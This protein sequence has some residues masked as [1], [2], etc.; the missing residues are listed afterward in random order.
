MKHK[1]LILIVDDLKSNRMVIKKV[2]QNNYDFIEAGDGIE[3]INLLN[4]FTPD[5][6]LV[7]AIMPN[8]DGFETILKIRKMKKYARTPIL[9]I[10]SLSD[11]KMKVKALEYGVNDFL[12]KPFDKYELRARC[13][14]YVE[15]VQLNKQYSDA[16]I[17]PISGFK[18]EISLIKEIVPNDSIFLISI[19]DFNKI[20]GTYGFRN[21]KIIEK[22]F[23]NYLLKMIKEYIS[24]IELYHVGTA[25]YVIKI[26]KDIILDEMQVK[27]LC[28]EFY[29]NCLNINIQIDDITFMPITTIIFTKD[30]VNLYEDAMSALGY[31]K[32]NNIK[33]IYSSDDINGIKDIVYTNIQILKKIKTAINS[34]KIINYYQPI[35][36]NLTEKVSKY[37]TLVRIEDENGKIL[38]PFAFLEVAKSAQVYEQITKMVYKNAFDKFKFNNNEFSINISYIDIENKTVKEYLYNILKDNPHVSNRITF[39]IL[40]DENIKD[41]GI[42]EEFIKEVRR[43]DAKI[44]IDDFGSGYSNFQ[45]ILSIEPDY[46]KIDGSIIKNILTDNKNYALLESI[47]GFAHNFGIKTIAEYISSEELQ[48]EILSL[49]IDYSQGYLFGKPSP[50]LLDEKYLVNT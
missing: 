20:H 13:K 4:S 35:Y 15:M 12:T 6:I 9:M 34:K 28:E 31:A 24:N 23:G 42:V 29:N 18:N 39:E 36:N 19:N 50:K 27:E 37:E 7:D 16:K 41:F 1:P 46:I 48:N 10:T 32:K 44:A 26:S 11:I 47:N 22:K 3:A 8:M 2:L 17:N 30:R 14:S 38:S 33:Y 43:Y 40:E 5:I 45:R 21:S 25:K 49:G